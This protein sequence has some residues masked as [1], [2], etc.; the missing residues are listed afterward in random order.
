[1][2]VELLTSIRELIN[3]IA[4]TIAG[5]AG[6][7][8]SE[9]GGGGG[10]EIDT[11]SFQKQTSKVFKKMGNSIKAIFKSAIGPMALFSDFMGGILEPMELITEPIGL[12]GE[13][14]GTIL[15]P[16]LAPFN[17]ALYKLAE[18]L[19]E[20]MTRIEP[21][22][23]YIEKVVSLLLY[24]VIEVLYNNFMFVFNQFKVKLEFLIT[25]VKNIVGLFTGEISFSEFAA[26]VWAAMQTMLQG[27]WANVET[28]FGGIWTA[29]RRVFGDLL[30]KVMGFISDYI[31]GIGDF[32]QGEGK[33]GDAWYNP[34]SW[35][36]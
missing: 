18:Y 24:L 11:K 12:L 32:T 5:I 27:I 3:E 22:Y 7:D 10:G 15:Y 20:I 2:M 1:M 25:L 16:V 14:V 35:G 31:S 26:N 6:I 30:D 29:L 13:I 21:Y 23:P 4:S 36:S 17:E 34:F 8:R 9:G 28:W 19:S 33:Y